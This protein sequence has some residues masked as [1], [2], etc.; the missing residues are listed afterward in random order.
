M[1]ATDGNE[2]GRNCEVKGKELIEGIRKRTLKE[3]MEEIE[4]G[5]SQRLG[6]N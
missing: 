6:G 2:L 4:K 3:L 5:T 1:E